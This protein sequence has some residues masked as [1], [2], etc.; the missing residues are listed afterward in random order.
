[1]ARGETIRRLFLISSTRR[2]FPITLPR[3]TMRRWAELSYPFYVNF[4]L[5]GWFHWRLGVH[6]AALSIGSNF[7]PPLLGVAW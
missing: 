2:K 1:M 7:K 6:W 5:P 4:L 3:N